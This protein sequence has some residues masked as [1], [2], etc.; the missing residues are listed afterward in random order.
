[1]IYVGNLPFTA[2]ED[3]VRNELFSGFEVAEAR[4]VTRPDGSSKGFAF[5]TLTS[6]SEQ[7]RAL[8]ELKECT[9]DSRTLIIRAAYEKDPA[10]EAKE[11]E[12]NAA[13]AN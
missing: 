1:M 6:E 3:F 4:L 8:E 7:K 11:G 2:S 12:E 5:V 9:C 13:D 10:T